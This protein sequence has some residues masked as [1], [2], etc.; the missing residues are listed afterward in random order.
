MLNR[1]DKNGKHE[2]YQFFK[3][4]EHKGIKFEKGERISR[5][6]QHHEWEYFSKEGIHK[7]AID[8][9]SGKIYKSPVKGRTLK[10]I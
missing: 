3:K 6:T 5:D 4:C 7:G 8:P 10:N 9:K 2:C 1:A